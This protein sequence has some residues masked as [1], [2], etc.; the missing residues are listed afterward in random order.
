[1]K[2]IRY[3]LSSSLLLTTLVACGG[4]RIPVTGPGLQNMTPTRVS[5][6]WVTKQKSPHIPGEV[7]VQVNQGF[8]T[9]SL[10]ALTASGS[11]PKQRLRI[12]NQEFMLME[13][14]AQQ[15]VN[16]IAADLRQDPNVQYAAPNPR[17]M[18]LGN[19]APPRP[20]S[21]SS[22]PP[23]FRSFADPTTAGQVKAA[24]ALNDAFF[25]MQWALPKI[26]IPNAWT[27][28]GE[29]SKDLLIA[30][31]DSGVDYKHP[32]L[33][34]QIINGKDF[35]SDQISG[36]NGEGSPDVIDDDPLDQ[37]GH[38]THV[39]GIITAIPNNATGVAG[40]APGV[41]LLNVKALNAEGWGSAFAIAQGITYAVDQGARV[42]NLSLGSPEGSKPIELAIKY[43]QKKGVLVIAAAGNSY[44]HTGYPASYP[45]VLAVGA[46]DDK[47]WL[48][49]FSNHDSRINVV[50]PGVDIISTTPTFLTN[51]MAQ[52]GIES[53]Y[54]VMSGTSMACPMVTAQAA[55]LLSRNPHLTAD[56]VAFMIEKSAAKIG[57]ERIFGQ[58]RIQ[59]DASLDLLAAQYPDGPP[60]GADTPPAAAPGNAPATAPVVPPQ[61][62]PQTG[63]SAQSYG[64]RQ[65]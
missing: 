49:D 14:P 26:G 27:R 50:A 34:G 20:L 3:F 22:M 42:I 60:T 57:D 1:M 58:G 19:M 24:A 36:P 16:Q 21:Y 17:Y 62:A 12:E 54:S 39:A 35:M 5:A 32:D 56:E 25:Q 18:A 38:G 59:I 4:P 9:Q 51:T 13:V 65:Y 2:S 41:K 37:M 8:G 6:K 61:T 44:T 33:K 40:I 28:G 15:D 11:R 55:L 30:M 48:A 31:V 43:A 10:H 29:G 47:D 53:H 45:G 63:V 46:T 23:A 64:R 52:N 7:V